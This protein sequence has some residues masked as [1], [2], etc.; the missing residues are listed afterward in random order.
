MGKN[1]LRK[2]S[3]CCSGVRFFSFLPQKVSKKW[4]SLQNSVRSLIF[5]IRHRR[6]YAT[7]TG[8][9][10]LKLRF[11]PIWHPY[12]MRIHPHTA[13]GISNFSVFFPHHHNELIQHR[14]I[15]HAGKVGGAVFCGHAVALHPTP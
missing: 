12:G 4:G 3:V 10:F 2:Q 14:I 1:A 9:V 7:P 8:L 11:L 5:F 6:E 15:L 13:G